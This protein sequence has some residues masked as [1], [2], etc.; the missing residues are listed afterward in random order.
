MS[1]GDKESRK[2]EN[3][4]LAA[5]LRESGCQHVEYLCLPDCNHTG[6]LK[7]KDAVGG[8]GF[9]KL[10]DFVTGVAR[11]TPTGQP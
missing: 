4:L 8:P 3:L 2:H 6:I 11:F 7:R 1:P 5:F 9:D 10:R